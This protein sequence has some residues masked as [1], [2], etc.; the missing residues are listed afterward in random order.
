MGGTLN[1]TTGLLT[2]DCEEWTNLTDVASLLLLDVSGDDASGFA[3]SVAQV[4][5]GEGVQLAVQLSNDQR[6]AALAKATVPPTWD[7]SPVVLEILA[8]GLVDYSGNSNPSRLVQQRTSH[9]TT[10]ATTTSETITRNHSPT[11]SVH[12]VYPSAD[13]HCCLQV[14]DMFAYLSLDV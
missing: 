4:V 12:H 11:Q 7:G 3:L 13:P 9:T 1:F 8:N 6:L 2:I 5:T 10:I 14:P